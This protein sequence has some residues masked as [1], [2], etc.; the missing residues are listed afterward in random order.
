MADLINSL[1][2]AA[3]GMKAQSDRLRIVSENIANSESAGQFP[4]D[5]PYRRK[6][7]SF[8]NQLDR[9]MDVHLVKVN[10]YGVDQSAFQK[11]YN[12]G[13]PA[14]DEAGYVEMPNVNP[15]VEL[16]DMRESRRSYEANMNIVKVSKSM[17]MQTIGLLRD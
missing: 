3:S 5:Q 2:I 4:G 14:A 10:K 15:L 13:H 11:K 1:H 9:E 6:V 12:P 16:M 8:K 17:L 7:L